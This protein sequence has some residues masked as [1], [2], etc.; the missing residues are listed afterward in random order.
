MRARRG[1]VLSLAAVALAAGLAS[2]VQAR[3][4]PLWLAKPLDPAQ[5]ACHSE[6]YHSTT[7]NCAAPAEDQFPLVAD[8]AGW[9]TARVNAFAP[10]PA[11]NV[12]CTVVTMTAD[13]NGTYA[14]PRVFLPAFGAHADIVIPGAFHFAGGAIFL[15]CTVYPGGR[16]H[17]VEW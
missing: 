11:S 13:Y 5:I 9:F 14:P 6:W 12:G 1:I 16:I 4:A 7:N 2:T 17:L 10:S 15:T 3:T 8:T